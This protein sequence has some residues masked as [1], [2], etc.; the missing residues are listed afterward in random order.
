MANNDA[1][2]A[3]NLT[4]FGKLISFCK[5]YGNKYNPS[6]T[7]LTTANLAVQYTNTE[8]V[9]DNVLEQH[10][11]LDNAINARKI[12]FAPLKKL[13]TRIMNALDASGATKETMA[14]AK[15][16]NRK[17]QGT[18]ATKKPTPPP[19]AA[20]DATATPAPA[21]TTISVSQQ[22]FDNMETH[23]T[24]LIKLVASQPGYAPNEADLTV[25]ALNTLLANMKAA[26]KL[27]V[28]ITTDCENSR[29]NR[30]IV[31]YNEPAGLVPVALNVKKYVKSVFGATSPQYK[32]ISGIRFR[33][34][35][36]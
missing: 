17:I 23:V 2:H 12:I 26:N 21:P 15:A 4:N 30:D 16:I 19:A 36:N 18:R 5:G 13:A 35:S 28:D 14:D 27:V 33:A 20:A 3:K 10:K 34:I 11:N 32:Q 24:A 31:L 25:G 29:L 8:P 6:A 7:V 9:L 22:S 1:G